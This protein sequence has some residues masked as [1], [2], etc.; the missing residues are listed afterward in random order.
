MIQKYLILVLKI[1]G[2]KQIT[3]YIL[4]DIHNFSIEFAKRTK[5]NL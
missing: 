3:T 1:P 4:E 5:K 2:L